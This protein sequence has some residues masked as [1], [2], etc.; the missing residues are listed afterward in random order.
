MVSKDLKDQGYD[1]EEE[2]FKKQEKELL[3]K[4]R[5]KKQEGEPAKK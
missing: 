1:R 3:E 5:K 4:L 2:Y